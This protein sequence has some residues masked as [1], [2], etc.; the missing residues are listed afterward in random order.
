MATREGAAAGMDEQP[1]RVA[2]M[3][4]PLV[5]HEKIGVPVIN[6][7]YWYEYEYDKY[8]GYFDQGLME[9]LSNFF[10]TKPPTAVSNDAFCAWWVKGWILSTML[11]RSMCGL[12]MI[13]LLNHRKVSKLML[14]GCGYE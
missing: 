14:T 3:I 9:R 12:V 7:C 13:R 5:A 4:R 2:V 6:D 8:K 10:M 1:V 11:H